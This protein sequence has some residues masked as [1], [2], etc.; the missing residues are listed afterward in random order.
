MAILSSILR[1]LF[2]LEM[3]DHHIGTCILPPNFITTAELVVYLKAANIKVMRIHFSIA[4]K[5]RWGQNLYMGTSTSDRR[6]ALHTD[7]GVWWTTDIETDAPSFQYSYWVEERQN[8]IHC[9]PQFCH[10]INLPD[11]TNEADITDEWFS[12]PYARVFFSSAFTRCFL[13]VKEPLVTDRHRIYVAAMPVQGAE[14]S[15]CTDIVALGGWEHPL[16]LKRIGAYEWIFDVPRKAGR[17]EYKIVLKQA[18]RIIWESGSNRLFRPQTGAATLV[19]ICPHLDY[20]PWKGA[21]LVIPVFSLR[22]ESDWG[23]GDFGDLARLTEWAAA[24]N[25]KLIQILPVNDTSA[26]LTWHDSYPY[27]SISTMALHPIYLDCRT[28]GSPELRQKYETERKR[29]NALRA[30]DYEAVYQLKMQ[31]LHD[32]YEEQGA[33]LTDTADYRRFINSN[34]FWLLPYAAFRHFCKKYHT[35][36]F[37]A[38]GKEWKRYNHDRFKAYRMAFSEVQA[39]VTF[40]YFTQYLLHQQLLYARNQAHSR[41]IALKGDL[42]IGVSRYS[43]DVWTRPELFHA[44]GQAGAPP[45]D[46]STDGQNWGF[47]TYNWEAMA[48]EGYT[49]WKI[50]LHLMHQYFDAFRIDHVLGFFRIWEIP[51]TQVQGLMGHFRPALPLSRDEINRYGFR[52]DEATHAVATL[53]PSFVDAHPELRP[54]LMRE[55]D[56]YHLADNVSTQRKVI[57]NIHAEPLQRELL[58]CVAEVLFMRDEQQPDAFHPRIEGRKTRQY[59]NLPHDQQEAFDRLYND[60]FYVRHNDY[61]AREAMKK[62][63]A[64]TEATAMLPCAEDLGMIPAG[65]QPVLTRLEILSLEIQRMPKQYG[66]PLAD[67]Q[68]YPYLS[69]CSVDTHDMA[70]LRLWWKSAPYTAAY[71]WHNLLRETTPTPPEATPAVAQ[72]VIRNHLEAPSMLCVLSMQDLLA[73][74]TDLPTLSPE[75][76]QINVPANPHHYWRYRMPVSLERLMASPR[77]ADALA[78]LVR[79]SGR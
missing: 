44:N 43:M 65:V 12:P 62:L 22:S 57:N 23:I 59:A 69:V 33:A 64:I 27:N 4:Y 30:V 16:P 61:W 1:I 9:E 46:F 3:N 40:H 41:H 25:F 63:P 58:S 20:A 66:A 32:L 15:I 7:D 47:P 34:V 72:N 60:Y 13:P 21:G 45:D 79:Q 24:C 76:E 56:V 54:Y 50:R 68:H 2:S 71:L 26:S 17:F 42:P 36:C 78:D 35:T 14:W 5:T 53:F 67:T 52:L 51:D 19:H 29:L 39:E 70:P 49:W 48:N 10:S 74:F 6:Y 18:D 37:D 8:M 28:L 75:D 38:W 55:G 73:L 31:F 77:Y 11:T